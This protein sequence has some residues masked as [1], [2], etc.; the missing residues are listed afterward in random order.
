MRTFLGGLLITCILAPAQAATSDPPAIEAF[1][2]RAKLQAAQI[3]PSGQW[4]AITAGAATGRQVLAIVDIEG[5][6]APQMTASFS[7]ADITS[8]AWVSDDRLI[9]T[10]ADLL[11]GPGDERVAGLYSIKRDGT[12]QRRISHPARYH[13]EGLLAVPRGGDDFVIIGN[14]LLNLKRELDSVDAYRV[15]VADG[16]RQ[17]LSQDRPAHAFGWLF[18]PAGEPRVVVT[19]N[20]GVSTIY[21][22]GRGDAAWR[23]IASYPE[24]QMGFRPVAVDAKDTL[25]GVV[26]EGPARTAVLTRFDFAAGKPSAESIARTPGFD[27]TGNLI[28]AE[29]STL[30]GLRLI[31]DAQTTVWFEPE[32][33]RVQAAV[34]K[35][36]PGHVNHVSC[37]D[38]KAPSVVLVDSYSDQD[39]GSVWIYRPAADEWHLVG[40][41]RPDI[42]PSK[43][44]RL[45]LHRIKAR[46]GSELPVWVTV[47]QGAPPKSPAVVLVH[48][49]PQARGVYWGWNPVAQFLASRG[50]VVIEPEFRG[51]AGY[52]AAH[53]ESGWKH[54]GDTMQD[55]NADALAW[56]VSQ[57]LVDPARA[58]IAGASYGGYATLMSLIRYPDTYRCG[59][60]WAAVTDP[61]LMFSEDWANDSDEGVRTFWWP[62]L[63]GDPV[64]DAE[65]IRRATPA[66]R[67]SEIKVPL[68]LAFGRDDRRVPIEHGN[69]MRAALTAAGHPP[70]WVVY[71]G[72]GHG[73]RT[74]EHNLDFY[75]RVDR[76]LAAQLKP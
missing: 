24:F 25:Y 7:D 51:S 43:M 67:A 28:F 61:R 13:G 31:T 5:K 30:A 39:P 27:F 34:D 18:N 2:A 65:M 12:Q 22:R 17:M 42:D 62:Q 50:Y 14:A 41:R 56:A 64:K 76:F 29:D 8:F 4:L 40:R 68:L 55:D 37:T 6:Q 45:D 75:R 69:R 35:K 54:W 44:A 11:V 1:F 49:G 20:G 53:M 26:E 59:V 71:E 66:E 74:V 46:D 9:F 38:C 36:L 10:V 52:G 70:E 73:W 32:M 3:S 23:Q 72:E 57:G 47:P 21:W 48:G 19:A 60:A 16:Q 63:I 33:K 58:C 15:N